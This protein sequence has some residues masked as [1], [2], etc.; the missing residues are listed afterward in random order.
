LQLLRFVFSQGCA[1]ILF[2]QPID[3]A[4][5]YNFRSFYG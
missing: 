1:N 5:S 4:L 2:Y 3:F